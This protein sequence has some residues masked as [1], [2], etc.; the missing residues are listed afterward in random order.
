MEHEFYFKIGSVRL[1]I[2]AVI[3][4]DKPFLENFSSCG[5][6]PTISPDLPSMVIFSSVISTIL[7]SKGVSENEETTTAAVSSKRSCKLMW[8]CPERINTG[9]NSL[10][11]ASSF[12][13][14]SARFCNQANAQSLQR[15]GRVADP[16]LQ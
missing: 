6:G 2:F 7:Q 11:R 5:R 14:K 1:S 8:E 9:E 15:R 4:S 13:V 3:G 10:I 12:P 16:P